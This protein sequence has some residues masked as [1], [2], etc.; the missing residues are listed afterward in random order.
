M[1]F[2]VGH[3]I[4]SSQAHALSHEHTLNFYPYPVAFSKERAL[5]SCQDSH[6][7]APPVVRTQHR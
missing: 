2:Y 1:C 5:L 6:D 4:G 7:D 3:P